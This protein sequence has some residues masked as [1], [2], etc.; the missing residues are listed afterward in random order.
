MSTAAS[1]LTIAVV[2]KPI[3]DLYEAAKGAVQKKLG[4]MRAEAHLRHLYKAITNVQKVKTFWQFFKMVMG[5]MIDTAAISFQ[6]GKFTYAC[7]SAFKRI[8]R[9]TQPSRLLFP[10]LVK[11]IFKE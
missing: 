1:A 7:P 10:L 6:S 8:Q 9:A 3:E 2:K 11:L 5:V 4:R